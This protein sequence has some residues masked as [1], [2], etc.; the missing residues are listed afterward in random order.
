VHLRELRSRLRHWTAPHPDWTPEQ[1]GDDGWEQEVG[2]Y[3]YAPPDGGTLVLVDPLVASWDA[4][5]GEVEQHGAPH[6]LITCQWH[7]RSAP[8]ILDRYEG[9]RTWVF[10]PAVDEVSKQTRVTDAFAL[11]DPLPGG[12]EAYLVFGEIGEVAYRIPEYEAVVTGDALAAAPAKPVRVWWADRDKLRAL[13]D[14]PIE[15]LLLTHGGPVLE[16][17]GEA[18]ARALEA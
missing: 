18:L 1:G 11:G 4:L 15:M 17:G 10:A 12:I 13:L 14:R 2:C 9:A 5:D 3:A 7:F 6:I 16:R 8:Q